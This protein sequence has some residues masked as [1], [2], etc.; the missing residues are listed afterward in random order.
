MRETAGVR[1]CRDGA[2]KGKTSRTLHPRFVRPTLIPSLHLSEAEGS[3]GRSVW[4]CEALPRQPAIHRQPGTRAQPYVAAVLIA[5]GAGLA[6]VGLVV[7]SPTVMG[8]AGRLGARLPLAGRLAMRDAARHRGPPPVDA[9]QR[10]P[11]PAAATPSAVRATPTIRHLRSAPG[12]VPSWPGRPASAATTSWR[13]AVRAGTLMGA[14]RRPAASREGR[15][16]GE[17]LAQESGRRAEAP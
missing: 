11:R 3:G 8:L 1:E 4:L 6:V 10:L 7:L 17:P 2:G 5:G 14:R 9:A 12:S 15:G 13:A 16:P